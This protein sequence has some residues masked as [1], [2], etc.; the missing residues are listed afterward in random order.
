MN[1]Y[2]KS[3]LEYLK[4]KNEFENNLQ[5]IQEATG[6]TID[7][8]S[9]NIEESILRFEQYSKKKLP[10]YYLEIEL[11]KSEVAIAEK[12]REE[13]INEFGYLQVPEINQKLLI[14]LDNQLRTEILNKVSLFE[15]FKINYISKDLTNSL[16]ISIERINPNLDQE[17]IFE[18]EKF[19]INIKGKKLISKVLKIINV[20]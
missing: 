6:L 13:I 14:P 10:N 8:Y 9:I 18:N 5:F 2:Q 3:K 20:G 11:E 1:I 15:I 4:L 19:V 7:L 12:I 16:M 17:N